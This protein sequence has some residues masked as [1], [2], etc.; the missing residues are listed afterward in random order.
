MA[1]PLT[2]YCSCSGR[3]TVPRPVGKRQGGWI[4]A[5]VDQAR[6]HRKCHT[7]GWALGG[8][9][10][11]RLASGPKTS[12]PSASILVATP[13]SIARLPCVH[14]MDLHDVALTIS[15]MLSAFAGTTLFK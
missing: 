5:N 2:G 11:R 6:A 4:V 15:K 12:L 8:R 10:R 7:H 9:Y 3:W 1:S 14:S 13:R